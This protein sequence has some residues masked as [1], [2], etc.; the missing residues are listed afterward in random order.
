[1]LKL[2]VNFAGGIDFAQG[3]IWFDASL[4]DSNALIFTLTGD[5][6]IRIGWGDQK[7][8]VITVGGF[9]PDS[10]KCRRTSPTSSGCRSRCCRATTRASRR[11]PTS[12]SPRTPCS[13]ARASSCTRQPA[14]SISTASSATICSSSSFRFHFVADIEAGLALRKGTDVLAGVSVSC[15]LSGPTPWHAKGEASLDLWLFSI[16]VGF[17]ETWGDP[18][19][20]ARRPVG[21]RARAHG[22]GG[23]RR[24]QLD[25]RPPANAQQTVSIRQVTPP[26]GE[27]FL[28]PFGVLSVSQ[29]VAPLQMTIDKFG[30]QTPSTDKTF[31]MTWAGGATDDANEE[32]AIANFVTLSDSDKL[33]R[34]SFE[35]MQSGL[36]FSTGDASATGVSVDRDVNVPDE[37]RPSQNH[38]AHGTYRHSQIDSSIASRAAAPSRAIRCPSPRARP[39]VTAP[40][41]SPSPPTTT[42]S[43]ASTI[44]PSSAARRRAH[45]PRRTASVMQC[46]ARTPRSPARC[47]S[48]PPTSSSSATPHEPGPSY[49]RQIHLQRLAA[50][51]YRQHHHRNRHTRRQRRHR[52]RARDRAHRC[53]RE[54]ARVFTK[55]SRCLAPAM[56]SA[57]TATSSSAP[58]R[59][60][61]SPTSSRTISPSSSSMMRISSG[62]TRPPPPRAIACAPGSRSRCSSSDTPAKQGEFT[63]N[64]NRSAAA[65]GHGEVERVAAVAHPA[66]G[67]G[68]RPHQ[69]RVPNRNRFR[70]VP[71]LT[72]H[73]R[74]SGQRSHHLPPGEPAQARGQ[75]AV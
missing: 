2:Q 32:F 17:D 59:T 15:E 67:L 20:D 35:Q 25:R 58:S 55:T 16:S 66:L 26:E 40:P 68:A 70:K 54:R 11:R 61:G 33:S 57:S 50:Q 47:K 64:S 63:L 53:E 6:A 28:A 45:K 5:M 69:R 72:R 75:H 31:A 48:S 42:R 74:R 3:L 36:R 24:P 62:A 73:A 21:R 8:L 18:G 1:M 10:T 51:R 29:K 49:R 38:Q 39:A 56:S 52:R 60:T 43:S 9:H 23:R 19:T 44:S 65:V 30:N 4:F 27:L 71:R 41:P 7:V 46:S 14:I 34:K 13:R 12:R 22:H 37:L